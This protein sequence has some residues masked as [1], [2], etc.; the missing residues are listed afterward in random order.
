LGSLGSLSS[1]P[2]TLSEEQLGRLDRLT[3]DAIDE[4]L[5]VLEDVQRVSARCVEE[6]LRVRSVLPRASPS[7]SGV[8][9]A[10]SSSAGSAIA[11]VESDSVV[12]SPSRSSPIDEEGGRLSEG[13]GGSR[14]V[15]IASESS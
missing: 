7:P 10:S 6:L 9:S 12:V 11:S 3:R 1:L 4:R 15:D 5:R 2:S 8:A 13:E 14:T